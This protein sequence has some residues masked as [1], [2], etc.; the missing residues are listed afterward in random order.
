VTDYP[1]NFRILIERPDA[2][3]SRALFVPI[4]TPQCALSAST[5]TQP[6]DETWGILTRQG[7]VLGYSFARRVSLS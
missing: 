2:A 3:A 5:S 4:V 7:A 1:I 6:A